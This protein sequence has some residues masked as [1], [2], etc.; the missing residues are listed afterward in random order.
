[1]KTLL[2]SLLLFT[3]RSQAQIS[4]GEGVPIK[5]EYYYTERTVVHL[6]NNRTNLIKTFQTNEVTLAGL[7]NQ[8]I[9][10]NIFQ[11]TTA[12]K[13]GT[14]SLTIVLSSGTDISDHSDP[15]EVLVKMR[16]PRALT[17]AP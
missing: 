7:T 9:D 2:L 17:K 14:N 16:R 3:T 13:R 8:P 1:M 10:T 12:L 15:L 4:V 11:L 5:L 6:F